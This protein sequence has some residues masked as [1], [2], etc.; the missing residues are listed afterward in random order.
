MASKLK[1]SVLTTD[2]VTFNFEGEGFEIGEIGQSGDISIRTINCETSRSLL[3]KGTVDSIHICQ[4]DTSS[5]ENN[6]DA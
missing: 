3:P 6:Q 2:R 4:F 1:L 5:K